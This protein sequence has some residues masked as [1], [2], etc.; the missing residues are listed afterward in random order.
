ME[1]CTYMQGLSSTGDAGSNLQFQ[2]LPKQTN[3][4]GTVTKQPKEITDTAADR[5]PT[6]MGALT[7]QA[8]GEDYLAKDI[9]PC[10]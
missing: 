6:A 7:G 2:Q 4:Q 1:C 3:G 8:P 10:K 5:R 9:T